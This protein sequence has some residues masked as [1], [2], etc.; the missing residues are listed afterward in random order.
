MELYRAEAND[1]FWHG[2]F[3]GL[4]LSHL[5]RNLYHRLIRAITTA[6][7]TKKSYIDLQDLIWMEVKNLRLPMIL[8]M[9][10]VEPQTASIRE[11]DLLRAEEN[12]LDVLDPKA[13]FT[14]Y[15]WTS[16]MDML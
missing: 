8:I 15:S 1:V 2:V 4:Y 5:R 7:G 14:V 13:K 12:M 10:F 11:F 6:D 3:G 9:F 16:G